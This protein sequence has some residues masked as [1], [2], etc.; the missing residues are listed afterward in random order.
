M[1][2]TEG[3]FL[4]L[5]IPVAIILYGMPSNLKVLWLLIVSYLFY[6][7]WS[8]GYLVL[9]LAIS[10]VT[11][12]APLLIFRASSETY[13]KIFLSLSVFLLLLIL[14]VFKYFNLL[15]IL[16]ENI[17]FKIELPEILVPIGISYFLFKAIS[18]I[19]DVYWE[20]IEPEINPFRVFLFLSF[21]P[22]ILSGPIQRAPDFFSQLRSI[23]FGKLIW[24]QIEIALGYLLLGMFEKLVLADHIGPLVQELDK[25]GID[26]SFMALFANYAYAVQLFTD[27]AGLTH[28]AI[29]LGLLFGITAPPNFARPFGATNMQ[30]FWMRWHM[31]LTSWLRDYLF[32][33]LMMKLRGLGMIGLWFCILVNMLLIGVW[34]GASLT[35]VMFGLINGVLL[36]ITIATTKMRN[37]FFKK[38]NKLNAIGNSIGVILTFNL[39]VFALTFFRKS[40]ISEAFDSINAVLLFNINNNAWKALTYDVWVPG[41]IASLIGFELGSGFLGLYKY[42][43]WITNSSR[44]LSFILTYS[45]GALLVIL[46]ASNGTQF[47][48]ARF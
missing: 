13:K 6:A 45:I 27:F 38:F 21:F 2:Y 18:Y 24:P 20:T 16:V 36:I 5:L 28:I 33:P 26:N 12:I 40:S 11:Y 32:M 31:S 39:V 30:I 22:Q 17:G 46:L 37:K 7:T 25:G 34:H 48:Y 47:I 14:C 8:T 41:L 1:L 43:P 9:L 19:V 10:I 3:I 35:F 4:W 29:G 42:G 15:E 44:T 23:N